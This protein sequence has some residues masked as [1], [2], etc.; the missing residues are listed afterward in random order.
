[1]ADKVTF[2]KPAAERIGRVVRLVE[3]GDREAGPYSVDVRLESET[4]PIKFCTW[5]AT[6]TYESVVPIRFDPSVGKTAFATNLLLG[7][8]PGDGWVTKKGTAGWHLIGFDYTKQAGYSTHEEQ[9]FGHASGPPVATWFR[10]ATLRMATFT[11]S[12]PINEDK[13]VTFANQASEPNTANVRNTLISLPDQADSRAC[14]VA[15]EGT[16]WY[17]VNWQWDVQNAFTAVSLTTSALRFDTLPFGALATAS[18]VTFSVP[19][20]TCATATA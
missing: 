10:R 3:A 6:W 5:T 17:L 16:G 11:G 15:S 7:L 13:T 9:V 18:T 19:I 20:T 12:W 8:N 4:K 1:M 14:A 2:T